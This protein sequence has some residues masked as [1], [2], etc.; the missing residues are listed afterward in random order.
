MQDQVKVLV[1][2]DEE[3]IRLNFRC[4]L[5]DAGY[6]VVTAADGVEGLSLFKSEQPDVVLT[7]LMMPK[8]TGIA[9]I[10]QARTITADCYFRGR[11]CA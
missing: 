8:M 5:E 6:Q 10:E 4:C 2:D 3:L 11:Y 9:F 7:D 1:I